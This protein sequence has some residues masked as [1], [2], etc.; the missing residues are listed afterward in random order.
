MGQAISNETYQAFLQLAW[1][2][3]SA[4]ANSLRASLVANQQSSLALVASGS[5]S[6]VG[7][8]SANQTYKGY[9]PGGITPLQI[10]EVLT[11]LIADYDACSCKL[12][13]AYQCANLAVPADLDGAETGQTIG[14]FQML[15]ELYNPR[16][17]VTR[18]DITNLNLTF[19]PC[20]SPLD[21]TLEPD[22]VLSW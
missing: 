3:A 4:E 15:M 11:R 17:V 5:I 16:P 7:K 22:G 2:S 14:I 20:V 8:N 13:L 12:I 19:A 1:N 18:G 21:Q 6:S 10:V 9:G